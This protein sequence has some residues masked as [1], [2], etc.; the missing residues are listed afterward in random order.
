MLLKHMAYL[1]VDGIF[2]LEEIRE[3]VPLSVSRQEDIERLC[4]TERERFVTVK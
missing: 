4:E 3:T 2:L 1:T